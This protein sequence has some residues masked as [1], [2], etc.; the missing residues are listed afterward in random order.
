LLLEEYNPKIIHIKGV[1]NTV[2]DVLSDLIAN[3]TKLTT[4]NA[5]LVESVV[6]LTKANEAL[7]AKLN[8]AGGGQGYD[9]KN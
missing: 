1:D 3:V 8:K 4:S 9:K 7:S 6:Q 2:A 5:T